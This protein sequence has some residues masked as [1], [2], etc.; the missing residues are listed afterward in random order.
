MCL[1]STTNTA[2]LQWDTGH[3]AALLAA[4]ILDRAISSDAALDASTQQGGRQSSLAEIVTVFRRAE[5]NAST[6]TPSRSTAA[7]IL[8]IETGS[9]EAVD[10]GRTS[11]SSSQ[12]LSS[13]DTCG[14]REAASNGLSDRLPLPPWSETKILTSAVLESMAELVGAAAPPSAHSEAVVE[15]GTSV[16]SVVG[17]AEGNVPNKALPTP[18][19]HQN[20]LPR[21][22]PPSPPP[23]AHHPGGSAG[24]SP[25]PRPPPSPRSPLPPPPPA[26]G[27]MS[28]ASGVDASGSKRGETQQRRRLDRVIADPAGKDERAQINS[29]NRRRLLVGG[30]LTLLEEI[31]A[32]DGEG[33]LEGGR[34][35]HGRVVRD[36]GDQRERASV[37]QESKRRVWVSEQAKA[38]Q[39]CREFSPSSAACLS[40][41]S[42]VDRI[43]CGTL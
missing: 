36:V 3:G 34:G 22:L 21:F 31:F 29:D 39:W 37:E 33:K 28:P 27:L 8:E 15:V 10:K 7:P 24:P 11:T 35:D 38:L 26:L 32:K 20:S 6:T 14:W 41:R 40:D 17:P 12:L 25:L 23:H 30:V 16:A 9:I 1:A 19:Q 4:D 5:G 43:K 42:T 2:C 18:S 13:E